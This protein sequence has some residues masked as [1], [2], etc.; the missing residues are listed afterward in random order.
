[1]V[2]FTRTEEKEYIVETESG[3]FY[4]LHWKA[5]GWENIGINDEPTIPKTRINKMG[6]AD[7]Q[8]VAV[9][10][11]LGSVNLSNINYLLGGVIRFHPQNIVLGNILISVF[12]DKRGSFSVRSTSKV[13][14]VY[15][16]IQGS[17]TEY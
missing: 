4:H 3:S 10:A 17:S 2:F 13:K 1:M 14:K 6:K 12:K 7:F 16:K 9:C 15:L 11:P 5:R 8:Y